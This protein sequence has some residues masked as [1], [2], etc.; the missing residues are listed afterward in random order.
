MN[1]IV[2]ASVS[3]IIFFCLMALRYHV[4][5]KSSE[6]WNYHVYRYGRYCVLHNH[7]CEDVEANRL[8]NAQILMVFL[9]V[10]KFRERFL[11][12]NCPEWADIDEL[13]QN[14]SI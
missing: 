6:D 8:T 5:M 4:V 3:I 14:G 7:Y 12:D 13:I 11:W 9:M 1:C 2:I 10:W